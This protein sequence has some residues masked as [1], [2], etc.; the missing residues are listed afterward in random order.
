[1]LNPETD[2]NKLQ[3]QCT[4]ESQP[5][6]KSRKTDCATGLVKK[7]W[8]LVC[9]ELGQKCMKRCHGQ[10][11]GLLHKQFLHLKDKAASKFIMP[12]IRMST[13]QM[14]YL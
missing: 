6:G 4:E 8:T 10:H 3:T 2:L 13:L 7:M 9:N 1:M 5:Y 11:E 12:F 14:T